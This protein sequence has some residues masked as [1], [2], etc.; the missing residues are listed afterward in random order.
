MK[1]LP[2]ALLLLG[3]GSGGLAAQ[4]DH[5]AAQTAS[6]PAADPVADDDRDEIVVEGEVPKENR[7]VCRMQVTT[8]SIMPKRVCR[9]QAQIEAEERAAQAAIEATNRDREMRTF[10]QENR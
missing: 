3:L 9:T 5:P 7:K 2:I 1:R 10:I 6:E 4:P 8:G